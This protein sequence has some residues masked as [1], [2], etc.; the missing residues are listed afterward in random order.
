MSARSHVDVKERRLRPIYDCLDNGNNKKA[1]QEADKVLRKQDDLLCAK[2]LK[3]LAL[4]RLGRHDD[5]TTLLCGVHESSPVD[6]STLQAMALCYREMH[7]LDL[8]ADMYERANQAKPNS[9]EILTALFMSH[10]R[11]GDYKKQQQVAMQ[12][13]RLRPNKNPYYFWAIMSIYMQARNADQKVARA[14]FL[15]LAERMAR[16][17]VDEDKIEAEAELRMFLIILELQDKRQEALELIQGDL[18]KRYCSELNYNRT[19]TAE[20]LEELEMW[21]Q[22]NAVFRKLITAEPDQWNYFKKYLTSAFQLVKSGWQPAKKDEEENPQKEAEKPLR[23]AYLAR[24]EFIK[25]LDDGNYEHPED[26]W[27]LGRVSDLV[28]QYY[29]TFGDKSCCFADLKLYI[30]NLLTEEQQTEILDSFVSELNLIPGEGEL[31]F[32]EDGKSLLRQLNI[33]QWRHYLGQ[34]YH[35]SRTEKEI[36]VE[37]LKQRHMHGLQFGKDLLTT[38]FQPS[39]PHL[40]MAAHLLCEI[41]QETHDQSVCWQAIA[42]L[43]TG[44]VHSPSNF[45]FKLLLIRLYTALG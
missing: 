33:M 16:K 22:M 5:S 8:I 13:H 34:F 41:W 31:A 15:P 37:E 20:L 23:S 40:L 17:Y 25:L 29:A 1:V 27:G 2:A 42:L 35:K 26:N 28:K 38:D 45:H 6:D 7:R 36:L 21:P 9:E 19:K 14:V 30:R 4:L 44:L 3:S 39:D 43:Q 12:L 32:P 24:L 10:V 18:A 11:L